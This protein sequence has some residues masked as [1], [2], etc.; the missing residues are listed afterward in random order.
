MSANVRVTSTVME[1]VMEPMLQ[2]T[3]SISA[4]VPLLPLVLTE[5]SVTGILTVMGT[6]T[7]L[8]LPI[9]KWILAEVDLTTPVLLVL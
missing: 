7:E 1:I 6:V 8:M 4:E 9:S 5:T 3:N 2:I